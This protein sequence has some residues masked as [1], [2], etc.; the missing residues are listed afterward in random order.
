MIPISTGAHLF[1]GVEKL[2]FVDA[3]AA[4]VLLDDGRYLVQ[5]RDDKPG[6][7][8]PGH[9]SLFGGALEP[10]EDPET[11]LRRELMEELALKVRELRYVTRF[12]FDFSPFGS[13]RC[14]R[15]YYEVALPVT[16]L[17]T[18]RLGEGQGMEAIALPELLLERQVAPYDSFALWLHDAAR[19]R[20]GE[21]RHD[22]RKPDFVGLTTPGGTDI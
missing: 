11:C 15:I 21:N 5:H 17:E 16:A 20:N 9:W 3:A 22:A 13:G 1:T 4:I 8:Y 12:D 7:F 6:I 18:L 19:R 10:G 2:S 14:F